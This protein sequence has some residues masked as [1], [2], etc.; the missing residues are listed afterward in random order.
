MMSLKFR[1]SYDKLRKCVANT[2]F[3]GNWRKA[4]KGNIERTMARF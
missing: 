3:Y 2:Q 1:G 4:A